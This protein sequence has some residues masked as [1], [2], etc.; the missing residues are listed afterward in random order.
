MG[1]IA[2]RAVAKNG[3]D[4]LA[5]SETSLYNIGATRI[6]GEHVNKLEQVC[7]DKKCT[8][9]VNVATNWGLTKKNYAQM[10][11]LHEKYSA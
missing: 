11:Q 6:M 9:V 3:A 2:F 10:V 8:M 4:T 7:G 5:T 1:S